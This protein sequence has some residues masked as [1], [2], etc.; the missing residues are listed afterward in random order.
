MSPE[1][2]PKDSLE[3]VYPEPR[4]RLWREIGGSPRRDEETD[5]GHPESVKS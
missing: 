4:M 3:G 5:A 2:G 1:K